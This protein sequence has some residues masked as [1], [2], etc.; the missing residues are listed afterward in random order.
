MPII[1]I[2]PILETVVAAVAGTIAVR[3]V[4]DL[5]SRIMTRK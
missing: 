4:N 1:I 2:V 5:Y 3:A